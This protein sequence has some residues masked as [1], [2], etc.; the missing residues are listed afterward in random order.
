LD[1][2]AIKNKFSKSDT[3]EAIKK[4]LARIRDLLE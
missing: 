3:M 2:A 1:L 4:S